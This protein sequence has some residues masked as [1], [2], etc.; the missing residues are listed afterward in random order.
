MKSVLLAFLT[1][2]MLSCSGGM[3]LGEPIHG[4]GS[5]FAYPIIARWSESYLADRAGGTDITFMGSGIDYEPVGSLAGILRLSQPE[6]DFAASDMPLPP[7][8][9]RK[10]GYVQFPLVMGGIVPVVNLDDIAP[11]GIAL[12]GELLADIYLGKIQNWSDP[13][14]AGLNPGLKLPDLRITVIHRADGSGSTFN[15]TSFLS[16]ASAE[17]KSKYGA[18]TLISWPLGTSV[19]RSS[20]VVSA[21]KATKGAIGYV[22]YGQVVRAELIYAAVQNRAGKLVRPEPESF[23]AAAAKAPWSPDTGFHLSLI[24]S[25]EAE[26]YPITA[27]TFILMRREPD[28][29]QRARQALWFFKHALTK[30]TGDAEALF[31]VPLPGTL[32][33]QVKAYWARELSFGS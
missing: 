27:V 26:A 10:F 31:Y 11:G 33:D 20:G 16:S 29:V 13:A 22:E 32:V 2:I 4:A 25:A 30:G 14:I 6:M 3:A 15:W 28:S 18:D 23:A 7:E 8:E 9:L 1:A 19:E 12:S 21:V 17:W 5:T 24:D